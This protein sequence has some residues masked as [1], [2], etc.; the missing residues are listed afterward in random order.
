MIMSR[1]IHVATNGII[2]F[3]FM[4]NILL[5]ILHLLYP[6]AD[7]HLGCFH[8]LAI[9]NSAAKNIGVHVSFQ[10]RTFIFS[11]YIPRSVIAGPYGSSIFSFLRKLHTVLHSG[12]TNLHSHQPCRRVPF[13]PHPL[14]HLLFVDF[15]MMVPLSIS[16]SPHPK[17]V[18]VDHLGGYP[19]PSF[20]RGP[21]T[22]SD[23]RCCSCLVHSQSQLGKRVPVDT[24]IGHWSTHIFLPAPSNLPYLLLTRSITSDKTVIPCLT[25]G[26]SP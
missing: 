18:S 22:F 13:S 17:V 23:H 26:L 25:A 3:F 2:S 10:I 6:F 15:L 14:Q 16:N 4:A 8:V 24:Q 5:Y 19:K 7:G 12:Y 1:S 21:S 9:V 20:L 11:R